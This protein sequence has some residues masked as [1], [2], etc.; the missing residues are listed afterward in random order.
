MER[1][2]RHLAATV[3]AVTLLV[4]VTVSVASAAQSA[5][6]NSGRPAPQPGNVATAAGAGLEPASAS[7]GTRL[8]SAAGLPRNLLS[9]TALS[10]T[11]LVEKSVRYWDD[12]ENSGTVL[13]LKKLTLAVTQTGRLSIVIDF[14]PGFDPRGLGSQDMLSLLID[15]DNNRETG[16]DFAGILGYETRIS[17]DF[18][19]GNLM[20]IVYD[21]GVSSWAAIR[22]STSLRVEIP[23]SDLYDPK[24]LVFLLA[25]AQDVASPLTSVVDFLPNGAVGIYKIDAAWTTPTTT[26]STTLA[27]TTTTLPPTT[28]T[29]APPSTTTTTTLPSPSFT[30]VPPSHPYSLQIDEMAARHVVDGY[31]NG[32]F[33]P[34]D[35]V[36]RLQFAK[37]IVLGMGYPVSEAD[38]CPF[39]DVDKPSDNLYPDNY[40]AVAAARGITVGV[41][42]GRFAPWD[43]I[44]RAQLITMVARSAGLADPPAGYT[45]PF[46][47]FSDTHYPWARKAAY[48]GLLSGLQ[49]MGAAY[50]FWAPATR[51]EVCVVL[52]NLLNR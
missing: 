7:M 19:S 46:A 38:V 13:D 11:P 30:D 29:T 28:T 14:Y 39:A 9:A 18:S 21:V 50:D 41:E 12:G 1:I 45:P 33:G 35:W 2:A 10:A 26:T 3:I 48:A 34:E 51:G 25:S 20:A 22:T 15:D 49:G 31:G 24:E 8:P 36:K 44:S 47:D 52:Y 4:A 43:D 16:T 42:P 27:P 37:M 6:G 40:I 23:L 5:N 32:L 17:F